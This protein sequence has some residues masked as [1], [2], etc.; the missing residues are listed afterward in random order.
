MHWLWEVALP[1]LGAIATCF[2]RD[3]RENCWICSTLTQKLLIR[4][5][6]HSHLGAVTFNYILDEVDGVWESLI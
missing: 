1:G 2:L 4:N 5:L 3:Q 6:L